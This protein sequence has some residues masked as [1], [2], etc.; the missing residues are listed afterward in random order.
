MRPAKTP[1]ARVC[2]CKSLSE[3]EPPC[4]AAV[5]SG[6][7]AVAKAAA[8][9]LLRAVDANRMTHKNEFWQ[10]P[11]DSTSVAGNQPGAVCRRHMAAGRFFLRWTW[12][13][14]FLERADAPCLHGQN[15]CHRGRVKSAF[16]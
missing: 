15:R 12:A 8:D 7:E 9:S 10:Y 1:S 5:L 2:R 11:Q 3:C 6:H 14:G 13:D 16:L 4:E